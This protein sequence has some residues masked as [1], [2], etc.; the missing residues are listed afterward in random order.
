MKNNLV[1]KKFLS[2]SFYLYRFRKHVSYGFPII[3]CCNPRVHYEML[4]VNIYIYIY[5]HIFTHTTHTHPHITK[6]THTHTDTLQNPYKHTPTHYKIYI[7]L[8]TPH[9]H[10]HTHITHTHRTTHTQ[11]NEWT[12][13]GKGLCPNNLLSLAGS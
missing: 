8:H 13:N 10:T 9:T 7:Y 2:C 12:H 4:C 3:N 6:P 1:G 5:I 11:L